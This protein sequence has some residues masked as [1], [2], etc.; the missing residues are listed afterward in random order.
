MAPL[1]K[2]LKDDSRFIS[3]TCVTAQH[4]QMLD[5]VLQNFD[6]KP[7]YDLNIMK[8][9]QNLQSIFTKI[10]NKITEVYEEFEP[11]IVLVH[12]TLQQ[13]SPHLLLLTINRFQ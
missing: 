7:N 13:H 5:Q 4:R 3:K 1:V 2:A 10:L 6:I 9:N 12:G 11:D 8:K